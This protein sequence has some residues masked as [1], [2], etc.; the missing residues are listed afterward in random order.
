MRYLLLLLACSACNT[1][2]ARAWEGH[3]NVL[4]QRK[5]ELLEIAAAP[6]TFEAKRDELIALRERIDVI[7]F[8]RKQQSPVKA[9]VDGNAQRLTFSGTVQACRDAIAPMGGM[10]W[11]LTRW[12]LRI[13]GDRCD[14]EVRTDDGIETIRYWLDTPPP[15]WAAPKPERLT[16][17]LDAMKA[18]I[19]RLEADIAA[20]ERTLGDLARVPRIAWRLPELKN[21]VMRL[22]TNPTW[23]DVPILDREL[24]LDA[25]QRGKLLEVTS[26]KFIH[27]LEPKNDFR[28]RG[29]V[30]LD[31][32][33]RLAWWCENR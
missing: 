18:E 15:A 11:A 25:D 20:L 10:R 16:K 28:L 31:E 12:R 3:R 13:E 30:E 7:G 1:E 29:M 21:I 23:C 19:A 8:A 22:E 33:G 32:N 26:E 6:K 9:F 24:A 2:E 17:N 14:W 27:P 5:A 4:D